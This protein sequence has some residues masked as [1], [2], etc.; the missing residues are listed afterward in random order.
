MGRVLATFTATS[1]EGRLEA[2][3][4][5]A[6][7]FK[8]LLSGLGRE[9]NG[10]VSNGSVTPPKQAVAFGH[11]LAV[12]RGDM[13]QSDPGMEK[14]L[15]IAKH[16]KAYDCRSKDGPMQK[17]LAECLDSIVAK[18]GFS[19]QR[20]ES[21]E[22]SHFLAAASRFAAPQNQVSAG[23]PN[24]LHIDGGANTGLFQCFTFCLL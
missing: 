4:E 9:D 8:I 13:M 23:L 2:C 22:V 15:P 1:T 19:R 5:E 12:F 21:H 3:T 24:R 10:A 6:W 7:H 16:L 20:Q 18:E 17:I 14:C 11:L